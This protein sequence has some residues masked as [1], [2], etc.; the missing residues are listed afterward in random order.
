[1]KELEY[2]TYILNIKNSINSEVKSKVVQIYLNLK[3]DF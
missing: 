1:M 3:K 2:L